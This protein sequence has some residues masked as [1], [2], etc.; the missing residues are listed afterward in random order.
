MK[1]FI[2]MVTFLFLCFCVYGQQ[3]PLNRI[4]PHRASFFQETTGRAI[5]NNETLTYWLY[6]ILPSDIEEIIGYIHSYVESIGYT[7]DFDSNSGMYENP[8]LATSVRSLMSFQRR[9]CSVTIRNNTLVINIDAVGDGPIMDR[10]YYFVSWR[11][12]KG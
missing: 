11:L 6:Q 8:R 3:L 12:I 4:A 7:I 5:E 1:K 9:N 2:L 10:I